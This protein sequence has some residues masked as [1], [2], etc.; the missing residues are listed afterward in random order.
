MPVPNPQT[1]YWDDWLLIG[2]QLIG[3][4]ALIIYVKK[5][6]DIAEETRNSVEVSNAALQEARESRVAAMLPRILV[7]FSAERLQFAE[8][9]I[10]NI[11]RGTA[12]D[13]K[14]EFTP[15]LQSSWQG[16]EPAAF[17][18]TPKVLPPGY[19]V[20]HLL[21]YWPE[22]FA[23][24]LPRQ[25]RVRITYKGEEDGKEYSLD[26]LLD[27]SAIDNRVLLDDKGISD[28]VRELERLRQD[29][30]AKLE[31][32]QRTVDRNHRQGLYRGER[33]P[34]VAAIQELL[35]SWRVLAFVQEHQAGHIS[36]DSALEVVREKA[37]SATCATIADSLPASTQVVMLELLAQVTRQRG[38]M[39]AERFEQLKK[40][41]DEL[42]RLYPEHRLVSETQLLKNPEIADASSAR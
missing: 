33:V 30:K 4:V 39:Y 42:D 28:V 5:T 17:F 16:A 21:D 7:Y 20:N 32:L 19:R 29:V 2:I 37:F 41:F 8:I 24:N 15:E 38:V 25:Y 36:W 10:E 12:V 23:K 3:M 34:A 18:T 1:I 26:Q 14:F 13:V 27:A 22:Y 6:W 35:I 31:D 11:G 40:V 9:V